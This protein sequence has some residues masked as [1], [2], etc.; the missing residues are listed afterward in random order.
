M[1]TDLGASQAL[2]TLL[3]DADENKLVYTDIFRDYQVVVERGLEQRLSACIPDFSMDTFIQ[4]S[5]SSAT[6]A[7]CVSSEERQGIGSAV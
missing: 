2:W 3:Q 1:R 5:A 6:L 4:V 7:C